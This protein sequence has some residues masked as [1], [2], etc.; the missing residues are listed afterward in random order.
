[1]NA[2]GIRISG[3]NSDSVQIDSNHV[4]AD[5]ADYSCYKG[6]VVDNSGWAK[7]RRNTIEDF[8]YVGLYSGGS[9]GLAHC[10]SSSDSGRNNVYWNIEGDSVCA[11]SY[12]VQN[13]STDSMNAIYNWYGSSSPSSSKFSGKIRWSPYLTAKYAGAGKAAEPPRVEA[14]VSGIEVYK[15]DLYVEPNPFN[16]KARIFYTV[17]TQENRSGMAVN[18][19]VYDTRG[20][21][22]RTLLTGYKAAGSYMIDW[23]GRD[24]KGLEMQ[25]GM[26]FCRY[27]FAG[28]IITQKIIL[29][30]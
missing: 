4:K 1:M 28:K 9:A 2:S 8:Y 5:T 21:Q 13:D 11:G 25:S 18:L 17:P 15:E 14:L 29:T 20:N 7:V 22:V 27:E 23:D 12:F 24:E 6:I 10:G 30:R 26:Y 16:V 19:Y 3:T